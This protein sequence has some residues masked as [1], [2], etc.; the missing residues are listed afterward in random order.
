M[1]K[2]FLVLQVLDLATT[3][4]G[5]QL[6]LAEASPAVRLMMKIGPVA[7]ILLAKTIAIALL[8]LCIWLQRPRTIR[9]ANYFFVALV[10]WNSL[11]V[12]ARVAGVT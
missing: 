1:I 6:G 2:L 9:R 5:L 8:G 3:L 10:I 12:S 11:L 7:G 4:L